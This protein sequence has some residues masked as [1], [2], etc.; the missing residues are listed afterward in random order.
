MSNNPNLTYLGCYNN[1]L[2]ALDVSSNVNLTHLGCTNNLLSVLDLSNN[3][4]LEELDCSGNYLAELDLTNNPLLKKLY[5]SA[6]TLSRINVSSNVS[7]NILDCSSG[8]ITLIE[9]T[10]NTNLQSLDHHGNIFGELYITRVRSVKAYNRDSSE[11]YTIF[12]RTE[13]IAQFMYSPIKI[14][15][16]YDTGFSG[17]ISGDDEPG[18]M[19]VSVETPT[20]N[21]I[22]LPKVEPRVTNIDEYIIATSMD[23][24]GNIITYA[25]SYVGHPEEPETPEPVTPDSPTE[26]QDKPSQKII[27]SSEVGCRTFSGVMYLGIIVLGI[28]M[29]RKKTYLLA[30]LMI[31]ASVLP[32]SAQENTSASDYTLPI[33]YEVYSPAGKWTLNFAFTPELTQAVAD[34]RWISADKVHSFADVALPLT[35]EATPQ[36]IYNLAKNGEYGALNLPVAEA[37]MGKDY[38]VVLCT[39][40]NDVQPEELLAVRGFEVSADT[41]LTVKRSYSSASWIT[42]NEDLNRI[43]YAPENRRIYL[44]VSFSPSYINTGILTVVRGYVEEEDPLYR[45]NPEIVERIAGDLGIK[46]SDLKYLT[47]ANIGLPVKPTDAMKAFVKS[48]DHEIILRPQRPRLAGR[49]DERVS[50]RTFQHL[51]NIHPH[52]RENGLFRGQRVLVGGTS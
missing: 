13:G 39:L 22:Y 43:E 40:S 20:Q 15:Y 34:F 27:G 25:V 23:E 47:R 46:S 18:I 35:W 44:A 51:E 28:S 7:L 21:F 5:C 48:D 36:E 37:G 4:Y 6:T 1:N 32:L 19:T 42:L 2:N 16:E 49:S 11:I 24:S 30:L 8:D 17:T 9:L 38:Y 31:T 14:V 29:L 50:H 33:H 10:N 52:R 3:I 45:L 41:G 26:S 12:N